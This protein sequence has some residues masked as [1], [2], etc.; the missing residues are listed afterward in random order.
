MTS[1]SKELGHL[2]GSA[3]VDE[4]GKNLAPTQPSAPSLLST[5]AIPG[6]PEAGWHVILTD[7]IMWGTVT[8]NGNPWTPPVVSGAAGTVLTTDG[9]GNVSW[10]PAVHSLSFGTT[11]LLPSVASSNTI[12]VTGT[13]ALAN[14][15]TGL[16]TVG[17][18]GTSLVSDGTALVYGYPA[19]ATNI[20]GG[21]PFEL[22]YQTAANTTGFVAAGVT[23]QILKANTGAA[24][25]WGSGTATIGTTPIT[26]GATTLALA[27]LTSVTLTQNPTAGF[28][29]ATKEYVDAR[30]GAL[31]NLGSAKVATTGN[32]TRSGPL[33]IDGIPVIAG[34]T[35]L[36]WKQTNAAENGLYLVN[37]EAWTYPAYAN[38]WS[39]YV[40]A[41]VFVQ[42]GTTYSGSSF[43]QTAPSGGTLGVTNMNWAQISSA[44]QYVG[45]T[46]IN[47]VGTTISNTG[48]LSFSAG[49]T[50][51]TPT[52]ATTGAVTLGGTLA[53]ANGGTGLAALGTGVATALGTNA[54]SANGFV[55]YS[56]NLGTPTAGVLSS[57]TG[58]SLTTGV[59]GVL[60]I[61]NGG[62]GEATANDAFNALAPTQTGNNGKFLTTDGIN[63]SW[64][65]NP[66]GT[67][68]SITLD[69][70]TTGLTVNGG[71]V[72]VTITTSG[73]FALAGVL[74]VANG[75]T[76][77]T[78]A[79][80]AMNAFAGATTSG[81]YLRGNGT[82]V[83]MSAIQ[84][85]DVPTLNQ[86]T[87]GT[88]SN[89]TGIVAVANGGTGLSA[90][91]TGVTTALG[92]NVGTAG[93]FVVNGGALGT[94]ASGSL[95]NC[96]GLSLTTGVTGTL[97]TGSGGTGITGYTAG[98][99]LY[100][101]NATTLSKLGIGTNG[102]VLTVSGGVPT[103]AVA[104]GLT[105]F[106]NTATPFNTA[107]GSGAGT[108]ITSG[109]QNTI[110]GYN[111]GNTQT[112]ASSN[113]LVGYQA[114]S[115][116]TG[117]LNTFI[118]TQAGNSATAF[119][120]QYCV[121]IGYN[122]L[123]NASSANE[124][125][126]IGREALTALTTGANNCFVGANSG[127][128][129]TTGAGNVALGGNA[130]YTITTT[131]NNTAIGY[132]ALQLG[133]TGTDNVAVGR[134]AAQY[135]TGSGNVAVGRD[136]M[137]NTT[138][139]VNTAVGYSALRSNITGAN[140]TAVGYNA[141]TSATGG[142][143]TAVGHGAGSAITTGSSN[144]L[145][146]AYAGTTT[147]TGVCAMSDGAGN[148]RLY[149]NSAGAF[150]MDGTNFGAIGDVLTSNGT[151]NRPT[152]NTPAWAYIYDTNGQQFP[153]GTDVPTPIAFN[154]L[155]ANSSGVSI[156]SSS[157]ITVARAGTYVFTASIQVANFDSNEYYATLF[158]AK[159]GTI[160]ANSGKI[161]TAAKAHATTDS[162]TLATASYTIKLAANEYV[163]IYWS[164]PADTVLSLNSYPAV[165]SVPA[166]PLATLSVSQV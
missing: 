49:T 123:S 21:N 85:A 47:V 127:F 95:S 74:D 54:N 155:D 70:G 129:L 163:E 10:E 165:G 17:V 13:L 66:S 106:T 15:G 133:A 150:S 135:A 38:T 36:V 3:K 125:V 78:T 68:T 40:G 30:T 145:V 97:P 46:G 109:T 25:T 87:T 105:G 126:A 159:N 146:G 157:R 58:L 116:V 141:L 121:G 153:L 16:S 52:L 22:P 161:F 64:A 128:S 45:G 53:V 56:G 9:A 158:Y 104:G 79:Q 164:T 7:P 120:G 92:T 33:T 100:A 28:D 107:L 131:S 63:T 69:P 35:V 91:G 147:L 43:Q 132:G 103:W 139:G 20:A 1:S 83:V 144:T 94:P 32:I 27:G 59:T 119:T 81:Q 12:T 93:A 101:T 57:C 60:P 137:L 5:P 102:Y 29:A 80:A 122:T 162:Y 98:D 71:T 62:T 108:A 37:A 112:T 151:A 18:N 26:L 14:G 90:L 124:T 117:S 143:N 96:I 77:Q 110:I 166:V 84:A 134:T 76:G 140:S 111:A 39:A 55:L 160:A 118:G 4:V 42:Q 136:A 114:G 61:A 152:W 75:G 148:I 156:V 48:V 149:T 88:A 113:T 86:N 19:R 44:L 34:D 2:S 65:S 89:V 138:S 67:V 115:N 6:V 8:I 50:G 72:P 99:L 24:P 31:Q 73:T 82:N 142:T 51:L 130:L 154:T 23:G 11:G 41:L